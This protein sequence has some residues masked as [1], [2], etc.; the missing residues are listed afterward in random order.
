MKPRT[1]PV[2]QPGAQNHQHRNNNRG[3]QEPLSGSK[4]VK[5]ENHSRHNNA[6][7]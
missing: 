2:T 1:I 3:P 7:G 5:N 6:E 4:S